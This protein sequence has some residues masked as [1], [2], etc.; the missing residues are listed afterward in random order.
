MAETLHCGEPALPGTALPAV[1]MWD[2]NARDAARARQFY[3]DAFG[4]EIGAPSADRVQLATVACGE[5]GIN[6]VIG[7][8]PRAG[9][10]DFDQRHSG[11]IVYIKVPDVP[12]ALATIERAG[13]R[14]IWG[15]VEVHPG[16]TI[17]QFEDPEGTRLGLSN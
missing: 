13:G 4:W 9:D 6:G 5:G 16:L 12:A 2:L 1:V 11:L 8:A 10:D 3:R 14:T 17:A 15:P 7:Q